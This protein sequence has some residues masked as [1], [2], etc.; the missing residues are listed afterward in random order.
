VNLALGLPI[1]L[2]AGVASGMV[3]VG[4]GILKVPVMVLLLG[5]PLDIAI[6]S[7]ALM[8]GLTAAAGF[9]GHVVSGHWDWRL[10]LLLAGVVFIG[11]QIGSRI[12]VRLNRQKLKYGFGWFLLCV[13]LLMICRAVIAQ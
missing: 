2:V 7:S 6:G 4:G 8:I 9:S 11:G 3:G 13:A 12:S 10:S 1:A 5:V